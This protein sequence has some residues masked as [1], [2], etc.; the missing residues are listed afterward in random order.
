MKYLLLLMLVGGLGIAKAQD[1]NVL[2][3]PDSLST[4]ADAVLRNEEYY[5]QVK[6]ADEVVIK[7]KY[8][9]TIYNENGD[10]YAAYS[11]I[12]DPRQPLSNIDGNLYD[13][14]GK[15]LKNVK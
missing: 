14:S 6:A 4:N 3:V 15:K 9:I 10:E 11:N 8:A 12:Y 13:A 5:V 7:H 2:L 1:Y